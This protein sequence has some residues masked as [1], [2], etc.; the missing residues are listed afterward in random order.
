MESIQEVLVS[1]EK[2][3]CFTGPGSRR[4]LFDSA[5]NKR[6]VCTGSD[7]KPAA[8]QIIVLVIGLRTVTSCS[9]VGGGCRPSGIPVPRRPTDRKRFPPPRR[10]DDEDGL[11]FVRRTRARTQRV[12]AGRR[13]RNLDRRI[14]PV[15]RGAYA[16]EPPPPRVTRPRPDGDEGSNSG[17]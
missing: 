16:D 5:S 2:Y 12:S 9:L 3:R 7:W 11:K 13:R 15:G 17:K 14:V 4:A 1:K 6:C 10:G 8:V